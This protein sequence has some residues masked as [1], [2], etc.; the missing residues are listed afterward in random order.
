LAK[1][2]LWK[3]LVQLVFRLVQLVFK[4]WF[5]WFFRLVQLVFKNSQPVFGPPQPDTQP[6]FNLVETGSTGFC[7]VHFFL[8]VC[9][10]SQKAVRSFLKTGSTGFGTGSTGFCAE[11]SKTTSFG[12]PPIYTH[13]YLS[14]PQQSTH[15]T[16][17]LT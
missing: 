4:Y 5:S 3:I 9:C 1:I 17:F 6:V 7:T 11:K 2:A 16:S 12:A 8:L 15:K 14:P 10:A 13:S